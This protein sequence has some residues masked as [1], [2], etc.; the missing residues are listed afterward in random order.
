M[1]NTK[2]T[3]SFVHNAINTIITITSWSVTRKQNQTGNAHLASSKNVLNFKIAHFSL[4][5]RIS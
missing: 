4:R 2:V 3:L 5:N 1:R